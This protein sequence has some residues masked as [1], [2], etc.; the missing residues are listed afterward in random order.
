[1]KSFLLSYLLNALWQVP[2]VFAAAWL[3]ALALRRLGPAVEHRIWCCALFV[4]AVL[5]ACNVDMRAFAA[6]LANLFL[7]HTRDGRGPTVTVTTEFYVPAATQL[8][9]IIPSLILIAYAVTLFYFAARL[10]WGWHKTIVLRHHATAAPD[11]AAIA[12]IWHRCA[13]RFAVRNAHLATSSDIPGPVTIG[14]S[15]R[16]LLLPTG[17]LETLRAE[18]LDAAIAHEFAHMYRR[19]FAKN[20]VYEVLS[21]PIAWHPALWLTRSRIA[22]SRELLCDALAAEAVAGKQQYARSLVRLASEFAHRTQRPATHAIGIFDANNFER[23]IMN[24]TQT[25]L[26]LRG[27]K[28]FAAIAICLVLC[29]G[30]CA[31]AL[32][33]HIQVDP[34][35]APAPPPVPALEA[36]TAPAAPPAPAAAPT[37]VAAP[38]PRPAQ[39]PRAPEVAEVAIPAIPAVLPAGVSAEAAQPPADPLRVEG[40][41]MAGNILTKVAPVYPDDARAAHISGT[42]VLHAIIGKDGNVEKLVVV[43]GPKELQTS[44]LDAVKQWTY[45]PYLLNGN[46]TEV[47]TTIHVNYNLNGD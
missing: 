19:D 16:L 28:R 29:F 45:K 1:M 44:A 30:A 38:A 42:V 37:P 47:E 24:L 17:W 22:E 33:L 36:P 8:P 10:I 15:Q 6:S 9:T 4:E 2:F 21:L 46:P 32:A 5:P 41:V 31:S 11:N 3:A 23:R 20:L 12:S 13:Q 39:S 34:P 7:H 26:E 25:T 27:L 40:G 35:A 18:D 43:S 14:I